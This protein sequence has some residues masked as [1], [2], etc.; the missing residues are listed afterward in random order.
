[1]AFEYDMVWWPRH[2]FRPV[3]YRYVKCLRLRIPLSTYVLL[4]GTGSSINW[5]FTLPK[6]RV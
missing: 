4:Q 6:V 5:A 3:V 2:A 1:M